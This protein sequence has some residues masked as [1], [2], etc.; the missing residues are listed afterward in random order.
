MTLKDLEIGQSAVVGKVGG[1]GFLR[2]HLLDMGVI[3]GVEVT[4]VKYAP[5][6]DP[7]SIFSFPIL[8]YFLCAP[9]CTDILSVSLFDA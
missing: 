8:F 3:P 7:I 5:M 6:G 9:M 4:V 1:T 2:Q